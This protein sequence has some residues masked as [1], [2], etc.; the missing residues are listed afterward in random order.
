MPDHDFNVDLRDIRFALFDCLPFD[1]LLGIP[2][3]ADFDQEMLSMMLDEAYKFHK[4]QVA[5]LDAVGDKIGCKF[6][7]G[8]VKMPEGFRKAYRA[9][10]ENHYL[11]VAQDEELGG[12][13]LPYVVEIATGEMQVGSCCSLS[14]ALGLTNASASLLNEF[15]SDELKRVYLPKLISGEWQGTM[16]LTEAQAGSAVGDIKTTARKQ[17]DGN[18]LITGTKIYIT[19]G[20]HDMCENHVHLVLARTPDAPKGVKGIS[21]FVVPK[22][23][24][25]DDNEVGESNDVVCAGIEHKM[26]IHASATCVMQ[27][28]EEDKCRGILIGEECEGMRQMFHMMNHARLGV[29][30]Q[31]LALASQAYLYALDYAKERIQ[32]TDIE[33]MKDPNA[34]RVPITKHPDVRRMLM[35]Q[36]AAVE[37]SRALLYTASYYSDVADHHPDEK[38]REQ[39]K[40]FVEF[41]TPLCKAYISDIGFEVTRLA[42]QT[43]GGAGYIR[44]YPI[45]RRMRDIKIASIYEGT[46]GIQALDLLGRK[47]TTKAGLYFRQ[48]LQAIQAFNKEHKEHP[49]LAKEIAYFEKEVADWARVTMALGMKGMSG[50]RR[51]PIL[52]AT[53]YLELTGNIVAGWLLLKQ[54]VLAH[55]RLEQAYLDKDADD[56]ESRDMLC[57]EDPDARFLF[58]KL[59]TAKFFTYHILPKN[60]GIAAEIDS[61]DRSALTAFIV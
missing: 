53:P 6:E 55:A 22:F 40:N 56:W 28:G 38:A 50:D 29:G 30:L 51:Y 21:L 46:N 1:D 45:E 18:Y 10:C 19:A 54:A 16:C 2:R 24:P 9:I 52:S 36:K 14:L 41:F 17:A 37:S 60:R 34:Q 8:L 44:E 25:T 47:L 5:P 27:F 23:W 49:G 31:G 7:D 33:Q 26:G 59:E 57:Q 15:G 32:G 4:E 11:A 48:T 13:G 12:M 20:D 58:N 61:D 43:M 39:A 35:W 42:M 3:F